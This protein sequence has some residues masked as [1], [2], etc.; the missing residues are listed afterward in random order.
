MEKGDVGLICH[1]YHKYKNQHDKKH[2]ITF[3]VLKAIAED[4]ENRFLIDEGIIGL[5]EDETDGTTS[6]RI[7][8]WTKFEELVRVLEL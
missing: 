2:Y 5:V 8:D 1:I 6:A 4:E 3:M 7:I